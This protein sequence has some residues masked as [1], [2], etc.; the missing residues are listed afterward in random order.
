M[1]TEQRILHRLSL[2]ATPIRDR[3]GVSFDLPGLC[4]MW[5][6]QSF[7]DQFPALVEAIEAAAADGEDRVMFPIKNPLA[8]PSEGLKAMLSDMGYRA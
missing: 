6:K 3:V 7:I 4:M 8:V 1:T 2:G 5:T